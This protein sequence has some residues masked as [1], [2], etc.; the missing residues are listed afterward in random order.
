MNRNTF[1]CIYS[2]FKENIEAYIA[3]GC[4][5]NYINVNFIL[6]TLT[7]ITLKK[8]YVLDACEVKEDYYREGEFYMCL[9]TCKDNANIDYCPKLK[10]IRNSLLKKLGLQKCEYE[11]QP[12]YSDNMY[13]SHA[14][15]SEAYHELPSLFC[16]MVIPFTEEGI[17]EAF[18]LDW[19]S[20]L[21]PKFGHGNYINKK[22]IVNEEDFWAIKGT[23]V[24]EGLFPKIIINDTIANLS[25][26][27]W[28]NWEGLVR[29]DRQIRKDG[30]TIKWEGGS[31]KK[32]LIKYDCGRRF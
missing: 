11:F 1:N 30:N 16:N 10:P 29:I 12:K 31:H 14:I 6:N 28:S 26:C 8:D 5:N 3:N 15:P 9:Y 13:I 24:N 32:V 2:L 20:V 7:H 22:L 18:M 4:F 19:S 21:M 17:W 25:Y 23:Y 27:Y